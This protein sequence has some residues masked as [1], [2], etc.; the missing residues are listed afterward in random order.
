MLA[1][2]ASALFVEERIRTTEARARRLRPMAERLITMG[3]AGTLHARRRALAV[4]E[5]RDVVHKLFAEIAPRYGERNGGYTRILK[6]GPRKGDAAPMALIELVEGEA[7][8]SA[9]APAGERRGRGRLLRQRK[10]GGARR[11]PGER[12]S[13]GEPRRKDEEEPEA[14]P[15][16]EG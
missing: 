6:L 16:V 3:K 4:I 1:G 2:L 5:D 8:P 12:G 7:P 10:G 13:P 9:A 11:R 15:P 14:S